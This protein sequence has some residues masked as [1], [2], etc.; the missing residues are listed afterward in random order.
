MQTFEHEYYNLV[1]S[2]EILNRDVHDILK[3]GAADKITLYI[4][5]A[6]LLGE[7]DV[8]TNM[9]E[10]PSPIYCIGVRSGL[11]PVDSFSIGEIL[12]KDTN[13]NIADR[14]VELDSC[15][16][17]SEDK[18]RCTVES[19]IEEPVYKNLFITKENL[20]IKTEELIR[21][22]KSLQNPSQNFENLNKNSKRAYL[23][24]IGAL[25]EMITGRFKDKKFETEEE[26]RFFIDEMYDGI[27]GLSASNLGR[28]FSDAKKSIDGKTD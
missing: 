20:Y 23:N 22:K 13:E 25:L 19:F 5:Y 10:E 24:I 1:D 27:Y 3:W 4:Y 16:S 8:S 14:K 6:G 28:K 7:G 15:F 12:A 21:F 2:A 26:L 9:N 11:L 18:Y 17:Y